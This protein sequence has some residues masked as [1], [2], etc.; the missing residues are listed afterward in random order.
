MIQNKQFKLH[1][2]FKNRDLQE[3]INDYYDEVQGNH[4][5]LYIENHEIIILRIENHKVIPIESQ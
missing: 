2:Q 4:Q 1:I 3:F 5:V